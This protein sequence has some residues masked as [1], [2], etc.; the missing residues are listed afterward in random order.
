[1]LVIWFLEFLWGLI[2]EPGFWVVGIL[3]GPFIWL[4]VGWR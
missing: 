3:L 1:M 2:T 4:A